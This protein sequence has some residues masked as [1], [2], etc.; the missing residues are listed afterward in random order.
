MLTESDM[1]LARV[2]AA[3]NECREGDLSTMLNIEISRAH[4]I[5]IGA[6][7]KAAGDTFSSSA[8]LLADGS[9]ERHHQ[10]ARRA[11]QP[12]ASSARSG[13]GCFTSWVASRVWLEQRALPGWP[14]RCPCS[15]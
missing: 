6:L 11:Y 14:G 12:R 2:T 1:R 5:T 10:S 7:A 15:A 4:L 8:G 9:R 13:R 3:I